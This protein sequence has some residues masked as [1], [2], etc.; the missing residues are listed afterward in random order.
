[1]SPTRRTA[2][3]LGGLG[4]VL[5]VSVV[6]FMAFAVQGR[7]L[8]AGALRDGLPDYGPVPAFA[9]TERSGADL[10]L[11]D[12]SG[13]VWIA[14]FIFTSCSGPC[15]RMTRT[16]ADLQERLGPSSRIRLVSVSVDPERD[17]P[18]VLSRYADDY[19]ADGQR[20]LFLTGGSSDVRDLVINGFHLGST[21]DIILHSTRFVLVDRKGHIRGYYESESPDLARRIL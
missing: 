19:G 17:S 12:L 18:D 21:E 4:T 1:M 20:W 3:I 14:D 9:L 13:H 2:L 15:P 6:V 8:F 11:S 7:G 16:M 5:F 10:T